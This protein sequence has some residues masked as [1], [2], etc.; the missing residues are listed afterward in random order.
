M[1]KQ[2]FGLFLTIFGLL[3]LFREKLPWFGRLPGDF[4]IH[5]RNF[6]LLIPLMTSLL[7]SLVV[8]LLMAFWGRR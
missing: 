6:T 1:N 8:S 2:A 3:W 7:I 5:G 4:Q